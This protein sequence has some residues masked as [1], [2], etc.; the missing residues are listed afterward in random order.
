M[1]V[2]IL[3]FLG[4]LVIGAPIAVCM[5][6]STML[7][8]LLED[9]SHFLVAQRMEYAI[10]SFTQLAIPFFILAGHFMN[11]GGISKR[12]VDFATSLIG[13]LKGGLA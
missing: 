4:L 3:V 2:L 9:M 6:G 12:I 13:H 11:E 10:D 5:A 7:V 8:L 1:A